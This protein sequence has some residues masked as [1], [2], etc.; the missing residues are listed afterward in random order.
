MHTVGG[1]RTMSPVQICNVL[2][3]YDEGLVSFRALRTFFACV[4]VIASREA[5][6]RARGEK[7]HSTKRGEAARPEEVSKLTGTSTGAAATEMRKLVRVGILERRGEVLYIAE[8]LLPHASDL[9]ERASPSRSWMRPIPIPR[10]VLRLLARDRRPA[11]A[12]VLLA[13]CIRGLSLD[14]RTGEVRSRGTMKST[15][16]ADTFGISL[17]AAK[18]ARA[19]LIGLGLVSKDVGSGQRKLNRDGAYFELNLAWRAGDSALRTG[20]IDGDTAP[21]RGRLETPLDLE[22][23]KASMPGVLTGPD[24]GNVCSEDLKSFERME[25]LFWQA[26]GRGYMRGSEMDVL[27]FLGASVRA[28]TT[29]HARDPVRVFVAIVRRGLWK[30]ITCEEEERARAAL[31][32]HRDRCPEAFREQRTDTAKELRLAA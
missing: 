16:A 12:K 29:K 32:R 20:S 13:H 10:P 4:A 26:V 15:W 5:A 8:R 23:Q 27:N 21:P 31:S 1:Y 17:R 18:A 28:R 9:V 24:L 2:G 11:V 19:T 30:N 6:R 22:N 7:P 3:A 14:R 25:A